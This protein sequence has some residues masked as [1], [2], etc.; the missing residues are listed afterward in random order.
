MY[1]VIS[2]QGALKDAYVELEAVLP[3]LVL[4]R[5]KV[6][7]KTLDEC[8]GADRDMDADLGGYCVVFSQ[9]DFEEQ[10]EYETL[11]QTYNIQKE[12][13]EYR[14]EVIEFNGVVWIEELF[15]LSTDYGIVFFYPKETEKGADV[16]C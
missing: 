8:Y 6:V 14:D 12:E 4:E 15:I 5:L 11:L 3:T 7:L 10:R 1:H 16:E 9:M 13:Y 2:T